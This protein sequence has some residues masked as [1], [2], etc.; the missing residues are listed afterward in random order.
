MGK[1]LFAFSGVGIRLAGV[2]A[3]A[4]WVTRKALAMQAMAIPTT[5]H[6]S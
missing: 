1:L 4:D 3:A 6:Q 2:G 5:S